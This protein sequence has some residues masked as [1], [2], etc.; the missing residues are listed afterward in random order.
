MTFLINSQHKTLLTQLGIP[1]DYGRD[2]LLPIYT[3][4]MELVEAGPNIVGR[5]QTL[6][7]DTATSCWML[8][9][10]MKL[11][12]SWCRVFAAWNTRRA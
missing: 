8:P 9:T 5:M 3:E 7:P 6:T 12:W 2:P 4:A 11:S 10:Q 1:D